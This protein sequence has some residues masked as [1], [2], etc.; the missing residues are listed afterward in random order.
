M[1]M[2]ET[3]WGGMRAGGTSLNGSPSPQISSPVTAFGLSVP[4]VPTTPLGSPVLPRLTS[5]S[6]TSWA[7]ASPL[8]CRFRII[9]CHKPEAFVET[10]DSN[11]LTS[12]VVSL[13][14]DGCLKTGSGVIQVGGN[15][16][17]LQLPCLG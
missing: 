14:A 2:T 8:R 11:G 13:E 16:S 6:A 12:F 7:T 4:D 15:P 10:L 5:S 3:L 9:I 1:V 17:R